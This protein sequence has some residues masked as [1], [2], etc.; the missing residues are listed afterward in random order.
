MLCAATRLYWSGSSRNSSWLMKFEVVEIAE[1]PVAGRLF[2][3]DV[4]EVRTVG[5]QRG[6]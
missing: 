3:P 6:R 4:D 1:R 5:S 2:D